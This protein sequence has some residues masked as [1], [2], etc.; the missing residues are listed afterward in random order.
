MF[1]IESIN[2]FYC[3]LPLIIFFY[4][5]ESNAAKCAAGKQI[6]WYYGEPNIDAMTAE[7]FSDQLFKDLSLPLSSLGYCLT[8]YE[9]KDSIPFSSLYRENMVMRVMCRELRENHV[10]EGEKNQIELIIDLV[11]VDE[12][13]K[14]NF[15]VFP[16]RPLVSLACAR[17][18]FIGIRIIFE[19]KIIEN[20]RTQYI[21]NL[22]ITS[23]PTG[24]TVVARNGLCDITP[25]EWVVPVGK[26]EIQCNLK[27]YMTYKKDIILERPGVY[28][29]FLQMKRKQIY[30]SKFFLAGTGCGLASAIC[31]YFDNFYYNKYKN[32]DD[33]DLDRDPG[34]FE[35]IF[36][37]A[38]SFERLSASFLA[39]SCSLFALSIWF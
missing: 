8:K 18:D 20:L 24:V 38:Q 5:S 2:L 23:D 21:C 1:K 19:K 11:S 16:D 36:T 22:M 31:Y 3:I 29:Y 7:G 35:R 9:K 4:C 28:N 39:L 25:F 14:G 15:T 17:E 6:L 34:S 10:S 32:L 26:L 33:K 37:T 27:N 13:D 12:F 30:H